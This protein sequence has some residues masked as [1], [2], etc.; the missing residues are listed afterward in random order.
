M[1]LENNTKTVELSIQIASD[2]HIE[3]LEGNP[4]PLSMIIPSA[5]IL[6][7]AGDIGSIYKYE[8]L[9]T[10]LV[11][12]CPHFKAVLMC[13]GNREYYDMKGYK[14][15]TMEI[16]LERLMTIKK[17]ID[18]LHILNRNSVQIGDLCI[19]GCTLWSNLKVNIPSFIVKISDMNSHI[20]RKKYEEDLEYIEK[21]IDY[22]T[23]K[24][25][26]L[27]VVTHHCPTFSVLNKQGNQRKKKDKYIS[28]YASNLDRLLTK[29]KVHTWIFGHIHINFDLYTEQGTHIIG[30]QLGKP[31]DNVTDYNKSYVLYM[32]INV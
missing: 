32:K 19:V 28:L 23:E 12:L 15:T 22:C 10:F 31:K 29:E 9:E 26:K 27:V 30:N 25:L 3:Y 4:D 11:K 2:L 6:I 5:D 24:K 17:G 8:Q 21:M 14:P 20:Y 16:L 1:S 7:L 18:N 13:I